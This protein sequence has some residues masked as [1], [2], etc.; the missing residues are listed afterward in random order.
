M[1]KHIATRPDIPT[2][3]DIR[4]IIDPP[5]Q[6]FKPDWDVYKSLK[7]DKLERGEYALSKDEMDYV[8]ACEAYSLDSFRRTRE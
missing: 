2:P 8:A 4:N 6:E 3:S 1:A 7:A 5:K